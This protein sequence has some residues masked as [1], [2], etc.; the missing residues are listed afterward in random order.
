MFCGPA[1]PKIT[2]SYFKA[3][4]PVAPQVTVKNYPQPV[5]TEIASD[6][7]AVSSNKLDT[8]PLPFAS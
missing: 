2:N 6:P 7:A 1:V 4:A 5:Q 3:C 8:K